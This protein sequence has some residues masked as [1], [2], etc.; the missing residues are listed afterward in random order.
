[1]ASTST[2]TE[3]PGLRLREQDLANKVAVI[4][5]ASRGIGRGIAL[6]LASRGCS[7][8]GTCSSAESLHHIDT[9]DQHIIEL[10]KTSEKHLD[11]PKILGLAANILDPSTP[12]KIADAIEKH[13]KGQ[14]NIFINNA[15]VAS[16]AKIGELS[17]DHISD[18]LKGNIETPIQC[19]EEL[20]KRKLF[21]PN[22]RIIHISSV[23]ARKPWADQLM[24]MTTKSAL[25]A[26]IRAWADAF[27]G[28]YPQYGF[29]K[30]TTANS[31]M[32]GITR[33]EALYGGG[34]P[35]E[36]VAAFENEFVPAQALPRVGE[37]EDVAEVVGLLVREE[38]RWVTGGVVGAD[39]GG[40]SI[41]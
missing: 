30:G 41:L 6:N 37:V 31:L 2:S 3:Q 22:S 38:G 10:Y 27:G 24:Y 4:T 12:A 8:L 5:G 36:V 17:S 13:F 21:R 40:A 9:L 7:I 16:A 32:P 25:E 19:I 11:R 14:L 34:L 39:G 33:T 26:S 18:Y 28:K 15:C 35:E 20:V 29:M 23:R 1:M